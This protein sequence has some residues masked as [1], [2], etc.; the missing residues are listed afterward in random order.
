MD[1]VRGAA[2]KVLLAVHDDGAY[3][4]IALTEVFKK[5]FNG[6]RLWRR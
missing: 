5:F 4:N 2:V 3:A 1:K 6:T